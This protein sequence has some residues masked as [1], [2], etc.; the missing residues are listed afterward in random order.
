MKCLSCGAEK[1]HAV[2]SIS[3]TVPFA[4]KGG[5]VKVGGQTIT[6]LDIKAA[7]DKHVATGEENLIRGPIIC[8]ECEAE[9]YYVVRS[10][11]PLRLGSFKDA[12]RAGY[13]AA[14][15]A[16]SEAQGDE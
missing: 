16:V 15:A 1:L 13:N 5:T 2:V 12:V 7:W 6:Q 11:K 8:M 10:L 4:N 9:H 3:K 14:V